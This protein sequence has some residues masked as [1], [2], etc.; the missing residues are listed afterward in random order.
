MKAYLLFTSG[1]PLLVLTSHASATHPAFLGKLTA[2][3]VGKFIAHE[4]PVELA[5]QRYGNHYGVVEQ[6]LHETD[7]LRMLDFN[8]D[9]IFRLFR[10]SELGEPIVHEPDAE[11]PA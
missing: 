9:R 8:G 11:I 5:Q 3:G 4:V 2:K 7:D 10:F 6:D 1:G